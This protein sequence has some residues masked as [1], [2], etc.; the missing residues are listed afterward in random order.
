LDKNKVD[1]LPKIQAQVIGYEVAYELFKLIEGN[2][3]EVKDDSWKG[4]MN[5]TYVYGGKLNMQR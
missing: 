1:I 5:V 2:R 3:N 4:E